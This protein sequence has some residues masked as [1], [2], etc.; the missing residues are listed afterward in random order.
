MQAY[1]LALQRKS[2]WDQVHFFLGDA[3]QHVVLHTS[4]SGE[5]MGRWDYFPIDKNKIALQECDKLA[6]RSKNYSQYPRSSALSTGFLFNRR[7]QYCTCAEG[8]CDVLF[9]YRKTNEFGEIHE[10][11]SDEEF[12]EG[13]YKVEFD[14]SSYWKALGVSPFHEYADVSI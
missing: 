14:T 4:M 2:H 13:L 6:V 9:F 3:H 12:V 1:P 10:L 11:T 5:L 8:N 7:W